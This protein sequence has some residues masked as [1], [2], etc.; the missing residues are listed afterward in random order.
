MH[1]YQIVGITPD[2]FENKL[3][4]S[5]K[6]MKYNCDEHEKL[7]S[8]SLNELQNED[9]DSSVLMWFI[10]NS[11]SNW[12]RFWKFLIIILQAAVRKQ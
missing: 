9:Q 8:M 7:E 6:F 3:R 1:E 11:D 10:I 5:S 2:K 12:Y 4:K